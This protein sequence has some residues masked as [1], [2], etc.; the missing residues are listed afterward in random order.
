MSEIMHRLTYMAFILLL[1]LVSVGAYVHKITMVPITIDDKSV[2]LEMII[3][4]P[5]GSG[6]FPTIVFNHGS[7]GTGRDQSIIK[8][9]PNFPNIAD[10]FVKRGWAVIT[11]MRRGRGGSEGIYDEG[12][13]VDRTKGYTCEISRSIQGAKRALRDIEAAIKTITTMSFVDSSCLIIGGQS[14]GGILSIAYAGLHPEQVKGVINFVGGWKGEG[15][16]TAKE[17]NQQLFCLG[18]SFPKDTI[19]LYGKNDRYYSISHSRSNYKAFQEAGGKG[20]FHEFE[21]SKG[22]NGHHIRRLPDLW[23]SSV[24]DYLKALY[25]PYAIR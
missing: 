18:S 13:N 12:L 14:R 20:S 5:E 2:R 4:K 8:A 21:L 1:F 17:I 22:I 23:S 11:P 10:F 16:P 19:W 24:E 6:P 9:T 3:Y 25:L 15:C 7:S